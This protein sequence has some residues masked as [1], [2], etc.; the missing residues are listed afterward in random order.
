MVE[1]TGTCLVLETTLPGLGSL[2][3]RCWSETTRPTVLATESPVAV[4]VG[5]PLIRPGPN[6]ITKVEVN[7]Q[8]CSR[9]QH[10]LVESM[11]KVKSTTMPHHLQTN[12]RNTP[13]TR[14]L[15]RSKTGRGQ[16]SRPC[17]AEGADDLMSCSLRVVY[18]ST[19]HQPVRSSKPVTQILL[20]PACIS[21]PSPYTVPVVLSVH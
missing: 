15:T 21:T 3:P 12:T 14:M 11:S 18:P 7:W 4:V 10:S 1:P 9:D 8:P 17:Q 6:T 16:S 5:E 20:P 2:A 13:W 19:H